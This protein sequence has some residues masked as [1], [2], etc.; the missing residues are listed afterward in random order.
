MS[1]QEFLKQLKNRLQVLNDEELDGILTEYAMYIDEDV[2]NGKTEQEAVSN[3]GDIDE[4]SNEILH[5]YKL[6]V[7]EEPIK[8]LSFRKLAGLIFS[9]FLFIMFTMVLLDIVVSLFAEVISF[10]IAHR[11][12]KPLLSISLF[13]LYIYLFYILVIALKQDFSFKDILYRL[14]QFQIPTKDNHNEEIINESKMNQKD[15]ITKTIKK[16]VRVFLLIMVFISVLFPI[17]LLSLLM[18]LLGSFFLALALQ[19]YKFVGPSI[20]FLAAGFSLASIVFLLFRIYRK[21]HYKK[22]I[23]F[24]LGCLIFVG[25]GV[26]VSVTEYLSL[27]YVTENTIKEETKLILKGNMKI[28]HLN[29]HVEWIADSS[30]EENQIKI[31]SF[32]DKKS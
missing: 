2:K 20:F 9:Y 24:F 31:T 30:L 8:K 17:F 25:I 5:A 6:K 3:F 4:L 23:I 11:I 32:V 10:S 27:E 13:C 19:G 18:I 21:E 26:G 12:I 15:A 22:I 14:T 29:E 16:I 7:K 1:K 28:F